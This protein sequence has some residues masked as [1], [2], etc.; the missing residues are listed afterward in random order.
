ML[1][2][3]IDTSYYTTA[4]DAAIKALSELLQIPQI[5]LILF[6]MVEIL[7]FPTHRSAC[8]AEH[9]ARCRTQVARPA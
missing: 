3:S 7:T 5:A 9:A 8:A 2:L 1:D 6:P 4:H